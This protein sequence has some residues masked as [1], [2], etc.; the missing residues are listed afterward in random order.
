[1]WRC[2]RDGIGMLTRIPS[3]ALTWRDAHGTTRN[4]SELVPTFPRF[5]VGR[6]ALWYV[7]IV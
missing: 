3:Q 2:L 4:I 1:M 7:E 5:K 6:Q